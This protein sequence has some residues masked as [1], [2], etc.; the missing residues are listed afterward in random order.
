M[1]EILFRGKRKCDGR[2]V[3][4]YY[5]QQEN[6]F[7]EDGMPIKHLIFEFA[8]FAEEVDPD[9]IGEYTGLM[10]RNGKKIFEG[11]ILDRFGKRDY[12]KYGEWN[13]GCCNDVY[14]WVTANYM[15]FNEDDCEVVGNIWDTP[16]L[17]GGE[18][19]EGPDR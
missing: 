8:P 6:P 1:R 19:Q 17:L 12:V 10:D 13:C 11:D 9:T 15:R 5:V 2:W 14:G 4:G 7:T 18:T 3:E 16:E